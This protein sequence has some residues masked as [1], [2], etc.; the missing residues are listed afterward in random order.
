MRFQAIRRDRGAQNIYYF[1]DKSTSGFSAGSEQYNIDEVGWVSTAVICVV[2]IKSG[3]I[4]VLYVTY[5]IRVQLL[6]FSVAGNY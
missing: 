2:G 4:L 1:I 3:T 6:I 5:L